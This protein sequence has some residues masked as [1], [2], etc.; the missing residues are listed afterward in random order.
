[1]KTDI[2]SSMTLCGTLPV[3]PSL[4]TWIQ[5]GTLARN[6]ARALPLAL[7]GSAL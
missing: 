3:A 7:S 1:L 4:I 6:P 2:C 5:T